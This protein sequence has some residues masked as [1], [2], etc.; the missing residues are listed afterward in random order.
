MLNKILFTTVLAK[1]E[2]LIKGA[3][4]VEALN[5]YTWNLDLYINVCINFPMML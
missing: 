1:I 5:T 4:F 2:I 3:T